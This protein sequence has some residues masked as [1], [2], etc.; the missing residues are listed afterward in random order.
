MPA[1]KGRKMGRHEK[2]AKNGRYK[3]LRQR[4]RNKLKRILQSNGSEAALAYGVKHGLPDYTRGLV[5]A[6][7]VKEQQ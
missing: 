4:E 7:R 2:S 5:N 3:L 6:H 1:G